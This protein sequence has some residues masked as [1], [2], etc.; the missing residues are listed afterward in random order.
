MNWNQINTVLA[1]IDLEETDDVGLRLA[2]QAATGAEG[3]H[4]LYVLPELEPSLV[5][6]IDVQTRIATAR[7]NL[8]AWLT[9]QGAPDSVRTHVTT[10]NA[11]AA[12]ALLAETLSADLVILP[13]RGRKGLQ[14]ALLGSVAERAVRLS[15]CPVLVVKRSDST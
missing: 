6:Q 14:R 4:V 2:L 1:P 5:T 7:Q 10:G 15:P 9:E 12:I 3:V 11:A 8:R 13:S